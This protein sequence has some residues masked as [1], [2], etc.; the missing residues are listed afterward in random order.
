MIAVGETV[1]SA[2]EVPFFLPLS[3]DP[4]NSGLTLHDFTN[5]ASTGEVQIK[6]PGG[7][8]F[9][10]LGSQ[11]VEKGFG[12]YCVQLTSAQTANAGTV[13]IRVVISGN[14]GQPYSGFEPIGTA[15]GDIAVGGSGVFV[16]GL[17][18]ASDPIFGA[19]ITGH[20]FTLGEVQICVPGG[21]Y[22]NASLS[23]IAEIGDGLYTLTLHGTATANRGK[24]FVYVNVSGSQRFEGYA[25]I[26]GAGSSGATTIDYV[27]PSPNTTP[28]SG[29]GFPAL[30]AAAAVT[31]IVLQVTNA[32]GAGA[33]AFVAI[34]ALL[35]GQ[36]SE[37]VYRDGFFEGLYDE[38]QNGSFVTSITNGLQF[39]ITRGGG[40]IG[41]TADTN[42]VVGIV[43]D[44]VDN[45]GGVASTTA[46]FEMPAQGVIPS[47]QLQ[48]IPQAPGQVD[49]V[50]QALNYIA[51]QFRS[52]Q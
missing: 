10:V 17:P 34:T 19:P 21:S 16:F 47:A 50:A 2:A 11:I 9:N 40:W 18:N 44:V 36:P 49:H 14:T 51:D 4:I 33:I 20:S 5:N 7:N 39:T 24:D 3:S 35:H 42:L 28:G 23:D 8:F 38:E 52:V 15:P 12:R 26:L 43:V 37:T 29:G 13:Y 32:A 27:T 46:Y 30:Y 31:P 48:P 41:A 6:L 45:A 22:A 1:P 25:T